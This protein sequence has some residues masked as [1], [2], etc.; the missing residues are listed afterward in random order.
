MTTVIAIIASL[1]A[2]VLLV[3]FLKTR[4]NIAHLEK[5]S[6]SRL[7]AQREEAA[8]KEAALQQ[9]A[10]RREAEQI[11]RASCRERV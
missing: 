5:D 11:G 8:L 7:A 6:I 1:A 2:I 4:E 3:L 10:S 9:E